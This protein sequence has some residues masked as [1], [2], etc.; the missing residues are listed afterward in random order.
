MKVEDILRRCAARN[1]KVEGRNGRL[2]VSPARTLTPELRMDLRRNSRALVRHLE[3][4]D[5]AHKHHLPAPVTSNAQTAPLS[6]YQLGLYNLHCGERDNTNVLNQT[7]V[8]DLTFVPTERQVLASFQK[9]LEHHGALRLAIRMDSAGR[10]E[11]VRSVRSDIRPDCLRVAQ[12]DFEHTLVDLLDAYKA[13]PFSMTSGPL[14]R[15]AFVSTEGQKAAFVL[16]VDHLVMDGWSVGIL[17]EDWQRFLM[18]EEDEA[19]ATGLG[20]GLQYTDYAAWAADVMVPAIQEKQT[21]YWRATLPPWSRPHAFPTRVARGAERGG[22]RCGLLQVPIQ[23]DVLTNL[24]QWAARHGCSL[25]AALH[26]ALRIALY[27]TAGER[28]TP[29]LTVSANRQQLAGTER[30]VGC[31]INVLPLYSPLDVDAFVGDALWQSHTTILEALDNQDIPFGAMVDALAVPR[32]S[33]WHPVGQVMLLLQNAFSGRNAEKMRVRLPLHPITEHE[34]SF[35]VWDFAEDGAWLHVEYREDLFER[36][37]VQ[38]VMERF[39]D[40]CAVLPHSEMDSSRSLPLGRC[41]FRP[42]EAQSDAALN[43][44]K[45]ELMNALRTDETERVLARIRHAFGVAFPAVS[46][47]EL[48]CIWRGGNTEARHLVQR[49]CVLGGLP[50]ALA[51]EG[52]DVSAL[53]RVVERAPRGIVVVSESGADAL[54]MTSEEIPAVS[55][56]WSDLA[57]GGEGSVAERSA[58]HDSDDIAPL[59]VCDGETP[60]AW[61]VYGADAI[62]AGLHEVRQRLQGEKRRVCFLEDEDADRAGLVALA[63][64]MENMP[65]TWGHWDTAIHEDALPVTARWENALILL[66]KGA[67]SLWIMDDLPPAAY[68]AQNQAVIDRCNVFVRIP[69]QLRWGK[70]LLNQ[71]AWL[72]TELFCRVA[73]GQGILPSGCTYGERAR[74]GKWFHVV[75]LAPGILSVPLPCAVAGHVWQKG[76][77]VALN[78]L[79]DELCTRQPEALPRIAF[80]FVAHESEGSLL[81]KRGECVLWHDTNVTCAAAEQLRTRM[82]SWLPC[83]HVVEVTQIPCTRDCYPDRHVLSLLPVATEALIE[84]FVQRNAHDA[85]LSQRVSLGEN[86]CNADVV[87]KLSQSYGLGGQDTSAEPDHAISDVLFTQDADRFV[88]PVMPGGRR[89]PD[90]DQPFAADRFCLVANEQGEAGRRLIQELEQQTSARVVFCEASGSAEYAGP[91]WTAG[92]IQHALE[93]GRLRYGGRPGG[94]LHLPAFPARTALHELCEK[95][96]ETLFR[97]FHHAAPE[98]PVLCLVQEDGASGTST[99]YRTGMAG[100]LFDNLCEYFACQNRIAPHTHLCLHIPHCNSAGMARQAI[101]NILR[102]LQSGCDNAIAGRSLTEAIA[103]GAMQGFASPRRY[104]HISAEQ[105][106]TLPL[107]PHP[108]VCRCGLPIAPHLVSRPPE[109]ES[110]GTWSA[111]VRI[112]QDILGVQS[113]DPD[114]NFFDVGG[115]SV[116]IPPLRD[117]I[118]QTLGVDIGMAG[119][120]TYS[121]LKDLHMHISSLVKAAACSVPVTSGASTQ[122]RDASQRKARRQRKRQ[123]EVIS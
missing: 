81:D 56:L 104:I 26:T 98:A 24:R 30:M 5:A 87:R 55:V 73:I 6:P 74:L 16:C 1:L 119:I 62:V 20:Q 97:P 91:V 2:C 114:A 90:W 41:A 57:G 23:D 21:A 38:L 118:R 42:Q 34:L 110:G 29:I 115:S 89:V 39:A 59:V 37:R 10:P 67:S 40:A 117:K 44:H 107:L 32:A 43:Q 92:E 112:W 65:V 66:Q 116:L 28:E 7:G 49:A 101:L 50:L 77:S 82:P 68:L 121:N 93:Q 14:I 13:E 36:E 96:G 105:G 79:A 25:F 80:T 72:G 19:D 58:L 9:L 45:Q 84:R 12:E 86:V 95:W 100:E 85:S 35:I 109:N 106:E 99:P 123:R 11:Q 94:L 52:Q 4:T 53:T 33:S 71:E 3:R 51:H 120:F 47:S 102:M 22:V 27:R 75:P 63:A 83:T 78:A 8:L 54:D 111:L 108:L 113:P 76:Q 17:L 48:L 103:S 46:A 122:S 88:H 70:V 64:W 15:A 69:R 31:F 18:T 61:Q 60:G